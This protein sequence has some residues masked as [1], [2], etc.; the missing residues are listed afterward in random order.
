MP[1]TPSKQSLTVLPRRDPHLTYRPLCCRNGW[2]TLPIQER[3]TCRQPQPFQYSAAPIRD[4]PADHRF[5][6]GSAIALL[7]IAI[8]AFVPGMIDSSSRRGPLTLLAAVHAA[9]FFG[10]L[11]LYL[12]QTVLVEYR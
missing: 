1:S 8:V 4:T 9:A 7:A 5:Y 3:F 2:R 11:V 12:V 10:W 6:V